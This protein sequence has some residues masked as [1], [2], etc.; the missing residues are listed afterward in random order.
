MPLIP[1]DYTRK[2]LREIVRSETAKADEREALGHGWAARQ[3]RNNAAEAQTRIDNG[4]YGR[5]ARR[6]GR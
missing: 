3:H 4:Q 6:E 2:D 5:Q 1:S